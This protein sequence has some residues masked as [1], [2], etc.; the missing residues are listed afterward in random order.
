MAYTLLTQR[1]ILKPNHLLNMKALDV[2]KCHLQL[3]Y[4][5]FTSKKKTKPYF[6]SIKFRDFDSFERKVELIGVY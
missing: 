3:P 2:S 1:T 6:A 5:N 4:F